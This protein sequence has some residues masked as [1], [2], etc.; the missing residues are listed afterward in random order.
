M[1]EK[2]EESL[3]ETLKKIE[4]LKGKLKTVMIEIDNYHKLDV[5]GDDADRGYKA[6]LDARE[7]LTI[8]LNY[9]QNQIIIEQNNEIIKYLNKGLNEIIKRS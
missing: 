8:N 6:D 3:E 7:N 9:Y 5:K 4:V 1:T 2:L